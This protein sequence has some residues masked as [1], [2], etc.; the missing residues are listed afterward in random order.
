MTA[1]FYL[2][3]YPNMIK[4]EDEVAGARIC[5]APSPGAH[6]WVGAFGLGISP[7]SENPE[8]ALSFLQFLFSAQAQRSFAEGGGSTTRV[9]ILGDEQFVADNAATTGHYPTLLQV[10][11][12]TTDSNFFPNYLF[13]PQGG[14]IYDE[15]TTWYS[16][17]A[18]GEETPASAMAKMA[19]AIERHC[20]GACEVANDALGD[21]Y[22][23]TP[24]PFPYDQYG[25]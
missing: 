6:T 11:D 25:Y 16:S 10:L 3:Q 22:S 12:H 21:G 4:T 14:K 24:A 8:A 15:M 20:G 1:A 5:T 23:P 7:D 2:D 9:S 13:V 18:A 19:E 17:A